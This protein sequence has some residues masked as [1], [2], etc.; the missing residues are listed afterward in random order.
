MSSDRHP[1]PP[2]R[3]ATAE[4]LSRRDPA[5][6]YGRWLAIALAACLLGLLFVPK[7]GKLLPERVSFDP[8]DAAFLVELVILAAS[9]G[10]LVVGC[11]LPRVPRGILLLFAGLAAAFA[12]SALYLMRLL[13]VVIKFYWPPD[14]ERWLFLILLVLLALT[15]GGCEAARRR[16]T[17]RSRR[18]APLAPALGMGLV[19]IA[20]TVLH[21]LEDAGWDGAWRSCFSARIAGT[22]EWLS[23]LMGPTW[24]GLLIA[25][26]LLT[27]I[28][29][30]RPRRWLAALGFAC[31]VAALVLL[32]G[33]RVLYR[34]LGLA[35]Y[36][37]ICREPL[38]V[39]HTYLP[40][41][42]GLFLLPVAYSTL[43]PIQRGRP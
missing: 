35:G 28:H 26:P 40:V 21:V 2:V 17:P 16:I 42:V 39:L 6:H 13:P 19:L 22:P 33:Y 5:R 20:R 1:A 3:L 23:G 12:K 24:F 36:T 9:I 8:T 41:A 18:W 25:V 34:L 38:D 37:M 4:S 31:G 7:H 43:F 30:I 14:A 27:V 15:V 10:L 32:L 29:A 11:C